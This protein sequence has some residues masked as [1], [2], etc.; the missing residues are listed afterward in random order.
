MDKFQN[1]LVVSYNTL[2]LLLWDFLEPGGVLHLS[3]V[4]MVIVNT[5]SD[6]FIAGKLYR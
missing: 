5:V 4:G 1:W 3:L 6:W 2:T